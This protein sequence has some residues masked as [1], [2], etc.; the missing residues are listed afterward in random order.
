MFILACDLLEKLLKFDPDKRYTVEQALAH[1]YLAQLHCE[2][3]EPV[4]QHVDLS[5]FEFERRQVTKENLRDLIYHEVATHYPDLDNENS[6]V[7]Q[8]AQVTSISQILENTSL[9]Y[10]EDP[11]K[12]RRKSFS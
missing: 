8:D 9:K 6:E 11:S 5:D 4:L 3:D 1:P 12:P 2:E 7:E 10:L